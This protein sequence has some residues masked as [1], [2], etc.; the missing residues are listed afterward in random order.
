M[1]D[2]AIK[3]DDVHKTVDLGEYK[4]HIIKGIT[5]EVPRG[6]ILGII[7]PSGSGK[8]TLLGLV[9]GLDTPTSGR[10]IIDGVDISRMSEGRLTELRN[11]KIGFVFQLFHLIPTQTALQNVELPIRFAANRKYQPAERAQA[12]LE[13]L[14][15]SHR[16]KHRPS[17]L[18]GGQQQ[19]VAIAR[20]M[21]NDP[22][23]LLCDEP[24][25]NLDTD[26]GQQVLNALKNIRDQLQT[27]VIIVT[28]DMTIAEQADRVV[29]LD[30]GRITEAKTDMLGLL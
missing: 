6:Q 24:T 27:T 9:G 30:D 7:G 3:L 21:A 15:L 28:H 13:M 19:R 16:L 26:S 23:I 2:L 17:Q 11:E 29:I 1:T 5:L 25:G 22:P 8:S 10:V 14:G 12:L 18:S 4:L 20:A